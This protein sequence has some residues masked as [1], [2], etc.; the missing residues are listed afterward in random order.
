MNP[1][2]TTPDTLNTALTHPADSLAAAAQAPDSHGGEFDFAHLLEHM[3]DSPELEYPFGHFEIP[4]FPPIQIAGLS[5]DVSITKHVFFLLFAAAILVAVGVT[6]AR[7]ARRNAVPTGFA[8]LMEVFI[9]YIRD[10]IALPNMGKA[11]L[12]YMSFLLTTFFYIL[13][14]NLL[15][16]VPF[17]ASPT[18][19]I[20]VTAGLAFV[21]FI[22]IQVAAIRAQGFMHY[23]AH[24]TGGVHWAL[25]P[26]MV[27]IEVLGLITKPFALCMRLFANITGGHVVI[28]SLIGFIFIAQ[29][30]AFAAI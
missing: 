11:G 18:G 27:P 25:W 10:E 9:L 30:V 23:L 26:I 17:G 24:L 4:A 5:I 14:M 12:R 16:L 1:D 2:V 28:L 20:S 29:S 22:M 21:A 15:G 7:K 6:T 8:N 19:N 13:I 3:Y